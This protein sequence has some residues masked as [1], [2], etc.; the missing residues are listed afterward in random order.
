[1]R[2]SWKFMR[3]TVPSGHLLQFATWKPWPI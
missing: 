1:L 2:I 3:F